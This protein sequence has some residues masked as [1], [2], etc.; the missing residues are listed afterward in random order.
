[1]YNELVDNERSSKW[2]VRKIIERGG[3]ILDIIEYLDTQNQIYKNNRIDEMIQGYL[4]NFV[5][6]YDENLNRIKEKE[7][8]LYGDEVIEE[9]SEEYKKIYDD[10]SRYLE[11]YCLKKTKI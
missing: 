7:K 1:M 4:N 5:D 2:R 6:N 9:Y 8:N 3:L 10:I 11:K